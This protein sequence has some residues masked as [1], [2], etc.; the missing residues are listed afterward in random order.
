MLFERQEENMEFCKS[1]NSAMGES[2]REPMTPRNMF[3]HDTGLE[4][5]GV[6]K[7]KKIV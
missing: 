1:T 2:I 7:E 4:F 3:T 5:V 6:D